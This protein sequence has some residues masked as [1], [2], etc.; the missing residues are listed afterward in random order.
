MNS[1][2][3]HMNYILA[4]GFETVII[5]KNKSYAFHKCQRLSMN[6]GEFLEN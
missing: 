2:T 1:F 4:L 5:K 3:L 6:L